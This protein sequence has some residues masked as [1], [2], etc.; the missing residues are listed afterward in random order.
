MC[1]QHVLFRWFNN[2]F[3]ILTFTFVQILLTI[4]CGVSKYW[5]QSYAEGHCWLFSPA[6]DTIQRNL[7]DGFNC[8]IVVI[9]PIDLGAATMDFSL[10]IFNLSP[11]KS[12]CHFTYGY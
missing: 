3:L 12:I 7:A 8:L 10:M 4:V 11:T 2:E 1:F 5:I 9:N 6:L